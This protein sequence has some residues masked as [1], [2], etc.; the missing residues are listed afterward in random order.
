[1]H[2]GVVRGVVLWRIFEAVVKS[3]RWR[4]GSSRGTLE[5]MR[6]LRRLTGCAQRS[7]VLIHKKVR[8]AAYVGVVAMDDAPRCAPLERPSAAAF[9]HVHDRLHEAQA[10]AQ[11]RQAPVLARLHTTLPDCDPWALR[12]LAA[13]ANTASFLWHD[14]KAGLCA[15][16]WDA[17]QWHALSGQTPFET[18]Q[19]H[20][21][22]LLEQVFEVA[23]TADAQAFIGIDADAPLAFAAFAFDTASAAARPWGP[24]GEGGMFVPARLIYRRDSADKSHTHGIFTVHITPDVDVTSLAA[25]LCAEWMALFDAAPNCLRLDATPAPQGAGISVQ[26]TSAQADQGPQAQ[27]QWAARVQQAQADMADGHID[28]VVLARQSTLE[29]PDGHHYDAAAT[30]ASLRAQHAAAVTYAVSRG[31]GVTFLGATPEV[32]V[33]VQGRQLETQAVA[34]TAPRSASPAQDAALGE[35]LLR[36]AK[37]QHEHALVADGLAQDLAPVCIHVERAPKP[38]LIRLPRLQH[39]ETPFRATLRQVGG[40]LPL[41]AR[42][43]PTPATGGYP[44]AKV[45]TWLAT[46]EPLDRGLFAGPIGWITAGGDGTFAVALRSLLLTS[47]RAL[48]FAGAGIVP[49]SEAA[50]EWRE[51]DLK[52]TTAKDALRLM[53]AGLRDKAAFYG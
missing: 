9:A 42:L 45:R 29:A 46:H 2:R 7:G 4:L 20:C 48:A 27:A 51:I 23:G 25:E 36:S 40:I 10:R 52:L 17:L 41:C 24:L 15:A 6:P 39:L 11:A 14:G 16:A 26:A 30:L 33:R 28:K 49:A 44:R 12:E 34:G 3:R 38:R 53:P 8:K 18:A 32:L 31:D 35:Q 21:V 22:A 19:R 43:H 1:M 13:D 37:D 47:T 50:A 5:K